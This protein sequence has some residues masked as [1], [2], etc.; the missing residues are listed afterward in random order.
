MNSK[1]RKAVSIFLSLILILGGI[2]LPAIPVNAMQIFVKTLTGKTITLDVG[3]EYTIGTVKEKIQEKENILPEYQ[4][5]IFAGQ[6]L[7]N[8][9]TLA[10]YNIQKESTLHLIE[11]NPNTMTVKL[12]IPMKNA[13]ADAFTFKAPS[14]LSYNGS[15]KT[16]SVLAKSGVVGMGDITVHYFSAAG[17]SAEDEVTEVKEMGTYYVGITLSEGANYNASSDIIYAEAW[18]FT[19]TEASPGGLVP[20]PSPAPA[21]VPE[22]TPQPATESYTIPV[23]NA[24]SVNIQASITGDTAKITEITEADIQKVTEKSAESSGDDQ[25]SAAENSTILIDLSGA[26][27]EVTSV[28]LTKTTVDRLAAVTE[29][30]DNKVDTVTVQLTNAKVEL[31]SKTLQ[32]VS[33]QAKG[34]SVN[35]VVEDTKSDNLKTEQKKALSAFQEASTFEAYL[36][37]GGNR[38]HDFKGGKATLSLKFKPEE[39]KS[40]NHY[41]IYYIDPTG[42]LERFITRY[43]PPIVG[44]DKRA[45]RGKAEDSA[46][47]GY[48][49][50]ETTHFSDYA[51]V[52]D[53]KMENATGKDIEPGTEDEGKNNKNLTANGKSAYVNGLSLNKGLKVSQ[54]GKAIKVSY[55][56]VPGADGYEIY[57]Q[58]CGKKFPAKSTKTVGS[59]VTRVKV[60]TLNGQKIV[61]NKNYKVYVLAYKTVNGQKKRLAKSIIAHVVGAKNTK[62]SNPKKIR[63]EKKE[64]TVTKGKTASIKASVA[65]VNPK[66]KSLSDA[67][68]PLLRYASSNKKIATV[69]K[70]GK[71][72]AVKKG[73]CVIFVYA[74]NGYAREIKVTVK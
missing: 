69:D 56:K 47:T 58:Y 68:A 14:N 30:G 71:V 11:R 51:I 41:H 42:V 22:P 74:K 52:Y 36:E 5:L 15:N 34:D 20:E 67:H 23:E 38:I 43:L 37:S 9:R 32:A 63:L 17:C 29:S 48:L 10:D 65:L 27:Q 45:G 53:E 28:E 2:M 31:D 33:D 66:K 55:G 19:I 3:P 39:G 72:T 64:I 18:S 4:R 40:S 8:N 54:S 44:S 62:F 21:P 60:T 61:L 46:K 49:Q 13:T 16:A 73:S 7:E 1:N 50:F 26:K 6:Q 59:K 35:L 12:T 57:I 24:S 70:K 25:E